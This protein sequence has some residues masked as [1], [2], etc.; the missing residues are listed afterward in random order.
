MANPLIALLSGG[1]RKELGRTGDAVAAVLADGQLI[2]PLIEALLIG[3]QVVRARAAA[4]LRRVVEADPGI[5]DPWRKELL[6]PVM[7]L[8]QWEVR[9]EI[10][11][12]LP[13]LQPDER[14]ISGVVARLES[15]AADR[16]GIVR[17]WSLNALYE[18][19]KSRPQLV[20]QVSQRLARVFRDGSPAER[21]RARAITREL[22]GR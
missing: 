11:H 18:L 14:D 7:A 16:S 20:E 9:S 6:G 8:D 15:Y 17:T 4:V 21:A 3:D 13:L 2:G 5:A 1:K 10:C 22:D 19:S 12:I